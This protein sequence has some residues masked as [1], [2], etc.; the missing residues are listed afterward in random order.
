VFEFTQIRSKRLGNPSISRKRGLTSSS[1]RIKA[2]AHRRLFGR[3]WGMELP[4]S[5]LL[6][7]A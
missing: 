5:R 6:I 4:A 1:Y 2:G 3:E 7:N